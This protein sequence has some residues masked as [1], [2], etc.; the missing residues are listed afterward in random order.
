MFILL[1][2]AG[3]GKNIFLNGVSQSPKIYYFCQLEKQRGNMAPKSEYDLLLYNLDRK[4][5]KA[6]ESYR[7]IENGDRILIGLSGGKDSL[8]LV[9]LL[10]KR[11]KIFSPRFTAIAVHIRMRNISYRSDTSYLKKHCEQSGIPFIEHITEFDPEK[12]TRKS[13]CFLCSWYRRK[14]LFAIAKEQQCNKIA[15]GHHQDDIIQTLLM[16]M[17]FQGA[18]GTMPPRLSMSKFKMTIIRPL[19][20]IE[21]KDLIR[22]SQLS[23]YVKQEKSCPYEHSSSRPEIKEVI[24]ILEKISPQVRSHIWNSMTHIQ[25]EYLPGFT[26]KDSIKIQ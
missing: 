18:F 24:Q 3:K 4:V 2:Y 5:K 6:I 16:N 10:G 12:D 17:T 11:M 23:G 26:D 9:E 15:L 25:P 13:P 8:A 7:L 22:L 19:C 14:A 21:E 20:L 1:N